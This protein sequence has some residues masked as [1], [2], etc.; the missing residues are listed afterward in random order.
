MQEGTPNW[1]M[2]FSLLNIHSHAAHWVAGHPATA[3]ATAPS[4]LEKLPRPVFSL[5][6]SEATWN[7][8]RTL[9]DTCISQTNATE[10]V[11]LQQLHAACDKALLQRV[12]DTG[13]Y[14]TLTMADFF[15][16]ETKELAVVTVHKAVHLRNLYQL[17][18]LPVHT[19][20]RSTPPQIC[21]AW[22]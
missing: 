6:S 3:P 10:S 2:M 8:K 14:A 13:M 17:P 21:A 9:W 12:F 19:W 4:R 16:E 7:F 15:L 22:S 18:R 11:K 20:P 1:G 5:N